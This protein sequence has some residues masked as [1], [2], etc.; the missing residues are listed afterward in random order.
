M[1]LSPIEVKPDVRKRDPRD[2]DYL[3]NTQYRSGMCS[4]TEFICPVSLPCLPCTTCFK[5]E[6]EI[7]SSLSHSVFGTITEMITRRE[8]N[9]S[10]DFWHRVLGN[11]NLGILIVEWLLLVTSISTKKQGTDLRRILWSLSCD[12]FCDLF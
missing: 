2:H 7:Q 9:D 12:L 4:G 6:T 11:S 5:R 10:C 8:I 1:N 3:L